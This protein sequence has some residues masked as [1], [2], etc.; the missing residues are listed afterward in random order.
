MPSGIMDKV[1]ILGMGCAKFGER[2][3]DDAEQ[4]M[5]E[6]Y[7][8]AMADAGIEPWQIDA[9]WLSVA[10]DAVNVG[11]SGIPAAMALRLPNFSVTKVVKY[12]ANGSTAFRGAVYVVS[13]GSADID[14]ATGVEQ[15]KS[16]G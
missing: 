6:A 11:T 16:T 10:F 12:C 7:V 13:S 15:L 14:I 5:V 8:E 9:A 1:A 4:L 2:W 3:N